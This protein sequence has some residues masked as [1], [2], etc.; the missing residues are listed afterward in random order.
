MGHTTLN[1]NF[2]IG[3]IVQA[4]DGSI[5]VVFE[6]VHGKWDFSYHIR[7]AFNDYCCDYELDGT[8][9]YAIIRHGRST[10]TLIDIHERRDKLR[11]GR[12]SL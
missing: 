9:D 1:T 5:G 12:R 4:E 2:E 3:D 6:Y 10:V 11:G 7:V 8:R